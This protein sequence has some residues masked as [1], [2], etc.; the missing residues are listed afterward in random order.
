MPHSAAESAIYDWLYAQTRQ[1]RERGPEA[2]RA[3]LD[4][5]GRPDSHF[6]SIRVVGTNGK[7]STSAM[8]EAG[9]R[10][11]GLPGGGL[12]VGK[13]TSPHLQA[14]EERIAVDGQMISP[15][16]VA[17]FVGQMQRG[18]TK[19][20]AFFDLSLALACQYF[21]ERGVDWA[22]MEAGVGGASDATQALTGVRAVALTN[23]ALD[24]TA[25]LGA[26]IA[27]IARDKAGAALPGV[28]LLSTATGAAQAVIAEV[29]QER[30]AALYTPAS[31]PELF[32][33]D[34]PPA[35]PG[36]HQ[37]HNAALAAATLRVLGFEA[38]VGAALQATHP[39]RLEVFTLRGRQVLLDGAHNPHAAQALA[40]AVGQVDTLL[41]GNF[42]RKDTAATL[43]PLLAVAGKVV[44]TSPGEG[45]SDPYALAAQHGGQAISVPQVAVAHALSLTPL[46]G[47][48]LVAGSLY[49]VGEVRAM[50]VKG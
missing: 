13:F 18:G 41:F 17:Q 47:T 14:F 49:L 1:E 46:G 3:L 42:A 23:V 29:A 8:L 15:A 12:R 4:A 10:A 38:G 34:S 40:A 45:A 50:L 39:G 35:L 27:S 33:L 31:H 32:A 30:G 2:A 28:P 7:G 21:A 26:D 24:H 5:L 44:F 16:R 22:V 37:R 9:L 48:L 25:A 43:Q 11:A 20:A 19:D 6:A 36:P